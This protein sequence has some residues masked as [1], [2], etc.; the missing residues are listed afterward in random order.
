MPKVGPLFLILILSLPNVAY[1]GQV[2]LGHKA[3]QRGHFEQAAQHWEAAL[4]QFM[5]QG[6]TTQYI[7]TAVHLAVAYQ[8]LGLLWQAKKI[9]QS[10][11]ARAQQI[12][13]RV[14][15][16]NVLSQLGDIDIA[17]GDWAKAQYDLDQAVKVAHE[18]NRSLFLANIYNKQGNLWMARGGFSERAE[19]GSGKILSTV[20]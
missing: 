8:T 12:H 16:A 5:S 15:Y 10:A 2:E 14:R 11:Q 4:A 13:D 3:F 19:N 7:D 9:L 6:K 18:V 1:S 20:H 17:I